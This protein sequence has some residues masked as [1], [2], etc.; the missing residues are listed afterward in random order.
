[1]K[2]QVISVVGGVLLGVATLTATNGL[3]AAQEATPPTDQT[4][5]MQ[6]GTPTATDAE[7]AAKMDQMMDQCLAMMKMMNSMMGMMGGE[8]MEGMQ[9]MEG[10]EEMP[11]AA[12]TPGA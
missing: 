8:G 2:S 7:M 6:M 1:M 9:G 4:T 11:Q 10:M 3:L 12:A 5:M